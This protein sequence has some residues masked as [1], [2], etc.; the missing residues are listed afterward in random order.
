M[1]ALAIPNNIRSRTVQEKTN[2]RNKLS[3]YI[4]LEKT[5]QSNRRKLNTL[6]TEFNSATSRY[7]PLKEN[8]KEV[9]ISKKIRKGNTRNTFMRSI[10]NITTNITTNMNQP[11]STA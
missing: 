9:N 4:T 1:R 5:L 3:Q 7:T 2:L 10:N 11:A 6:Y 8:V